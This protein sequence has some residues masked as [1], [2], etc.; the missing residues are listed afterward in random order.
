MANISINDIETQRKKISRGGTESNFK[1]L[2]D[3]AADFLV[4]LEVRY[5][6]NRAA[7]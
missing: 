5:K 3:L 2:S 4:E 1:L 6:L 7:Y